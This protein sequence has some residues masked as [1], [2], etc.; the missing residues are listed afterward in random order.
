[1]VAINFDMKKLQAVPLRLKV[2]TAVIA[3][4]LIVLLLGYLVLD[5]LMSERAAAVDQV[6][7][8][9]TEAKRQ[10]GELHRQVDTYPQ[11]R[12]KYDEVLTAGLTADFD[13]V[14]YTQFAQS[15]ATEDHLS[16]LRFRVG[17]DPG[18]HPHSTKYR[19]SVDRASFESGG[20]LDTEVMSFWGDLLGQVQGHYRI[21]E[22]SLERT[23]EVNPPLLIGIRQGAIMS[24]L[25]ARI[26][27]QRIG[28]QPYKQESK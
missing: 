18:D 20:L 5:D 11:L 17:D 23:G 8:E 7:A 6:R 26:E 14:G 25:K 28:I 13:R 10:N 22:A 21:V 19:V 27:L 3:F 16:E 1:M 12:H 2:V 9:L 24:D 15:K 4:D